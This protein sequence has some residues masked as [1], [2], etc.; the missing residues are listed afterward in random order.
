MFVSAVEESAWLIDLA[1]SQ[2]VMGS[3]SA[4]Q[5]RTLS[6]FTQF[7][8]LNDTQNDCCSCE[9]IRQIFREWSQDKYIRESRIY[10]LWFLR[11]K[12]WMCCILDS[13]QMHRMYPGL[14]KPN[15]NKSFF[16]TFNPTAHWTSGTSYY[17][18]YFVLCLERC[19]LICC[20]Q[21][22]RWEWLKVLQMSH[23][24]DIAEQSVLS[25]FLRWKDVILRQTT[26]R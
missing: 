25:I 1:E 20:H 22:L 19:K 4:E 18:D 13:F 14:C 21:D 2:Q 7:D 16:P 23:F 12:L 10:K 9:I 6:D 26:F 11:L 17:S 24:P 8:V 15:F 3:M 5:G